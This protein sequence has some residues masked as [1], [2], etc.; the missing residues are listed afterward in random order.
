MSNNIPKFVDFRILKHTQLKGGINMIVKGQC[1]FI[2]KA[3]EPCRFLIYDSTRKN[4][5][6]IKFQ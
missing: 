3:L 5:L 6:Q 4:R 2:F 1:I